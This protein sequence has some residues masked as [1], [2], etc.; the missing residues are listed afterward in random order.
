MIT[1]YTWENLIKMQTKTGG[2]FHRRNRRRRKEDDVPAANAVMA[3]SPLAL[4]SKRELE[5]AALVNR[6]KET[7]TNF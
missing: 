2:A 7:Y 4:L 3:D 5:V 6:Q 1:V